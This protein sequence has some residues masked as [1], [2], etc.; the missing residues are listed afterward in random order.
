MNYSPCV[1]EA[2]ETIKEMLSA[3][4]TVRQDESGLRACG[5]LHWC[6]K[7]STPQLTHYEGNKKRGIDSMDEAGILKDFKGTAVHDH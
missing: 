3:S 7:T 4:D 1:S 5:K 2:Q 6:N